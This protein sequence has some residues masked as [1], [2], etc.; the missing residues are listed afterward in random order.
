MFGEYANKVDLNGPTLGSFSKDTSGGSKG[1][2]FGDWSQKNP[3]TAGFLK[4]FMASRGMTGSGAGSGAGEGQDKDKKPE[5]FGFGS[6]TRQLAEG[7]TETRD[8]FYMQMMPGQYIPGK[9]G[10]GR[11]ALDTGLGALTG[12]VTGG[13]AGAVGGSLGSLSQNLDQF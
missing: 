1:F 11:V 6:T 3:K 13:P 4:G 2:N 5:M 9:K 12:F 8:P 7:L 10:F